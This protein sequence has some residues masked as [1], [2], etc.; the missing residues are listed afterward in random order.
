MTRKMPWRSREWLV[1]HYVD[2]RKTQ[3]EMADMAGC[4]Y[5]SIGKWLRFYGINRSM[6]EPVSPNPERAA[7]IL[8]YIIT[9]K[10]SH[11]GNSPTMREIVRDVD[12]PSTSLVSFYLDALEREGKIRLLRNKAARHICVVGGYWTMG[13]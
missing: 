7:E 9:Y 10:E 1:E 6:R 2:G 11:D 4:S 13:E 3:H 12:I 5:K 8:A